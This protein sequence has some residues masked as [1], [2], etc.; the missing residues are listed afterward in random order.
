[1]DT[2]LL[3]L[4]TVGIV[5]SFVFGYVVFIVCRFL[6]DHIN[7]YRSEHGKRVFPTRLVWVLSMLSGLS[8]II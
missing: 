5:C 3:V 8:F 1:M 6:L 7:K 2:F 4:S